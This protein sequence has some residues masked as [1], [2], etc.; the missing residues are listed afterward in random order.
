MTT[1]EKLE[2]II[3]NSGLKKGFL[4]EKLG[5]SRA[6]L[7]NCINNKAEFR[8]SQIFTLCELLRIEEKDR[9]DIFFSQFGA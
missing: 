9:T 7:N 8:A 2:E 3:R 1:T 4:A 5:I 6:G